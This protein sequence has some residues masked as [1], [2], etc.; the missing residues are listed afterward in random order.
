VECA[1]DGD[2]F[3]P[4]IECGRAA[5]L[6]LAVLTTF[7]TLVRHLF[8]FSFLFPYFPHGCLDSSVLLELADRIKGI[9][10]P[11]TGL[12]MP[13]ICGLCSRAF[14]PPG[15]ATDEYFCTVSYV[16]ADLAALSEAEMLGRSRNARR[17]RMLD[18]GV[19]IG[20]Y[21]SCS[22]PRRPPRAGMSKKLEA[23][24][25]QR[26]PVASRS[27]AKYT[28][29][30]G[31]LTYLWPSIQ[32]DRERASSPAGRTKVCSGCKTSAE[33][34]AKGARIAGQAQTRVPSS[35]LP[36]EE[37]G[38]AAGPSGA[39]VVGAPSGLHALSEA[40]A[41]AMHL[42][43]PPPTL[44]GPPLLAAAEDPTGGSQQCASAS[45][46][47]ASD[48]TATDTALSQESRSPEDLSHALDT[49]RA[50]AVPGS[51]S[52]DIPPDLSWQST[53]RYLAALV[54]KY[55]SL[56]VP[57]L[58]TLETLINRYL[59]ATRHPDISVACKNGVNPDLCLG[60]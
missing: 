6:V 11:V 49:P 9:T 13:F 40:A 56:V 2:H 58:A 45:P 59:A 33:R 34:A 55:D 51:V 31:V 41:T 36:A 50:S 37:C 7:L 17:S 29:G 30:P 15:A 18:C 52:V 3:E 27:P 42:P 24:S 26:H 23:C 5:I 28:P 44:S 46:C 38:A 21:N 20:V 1:P 57:E 53:E 14:L 48:Q 22:V 25:S 19:L 47:G 54:D 43:V 12:P 60:T 10:H 8:F 39:M 4:G 32:A 35:T 16:P